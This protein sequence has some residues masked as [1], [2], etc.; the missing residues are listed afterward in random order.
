[1]E[2]GPPGR[3]VSVG[4]SVSVSDGVGVGVGVQVGMPV[5]VGVGPYVQSGVPV[6]TGVLVKGTYGV[7]DGWTVLYVGTCVLMG[8]VGLGVFFPCPWHG[9]AFTSREARQRPRSNEVLAACGNQRRMRVRADRRIG[10]T[11]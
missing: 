4:V 2:V 6:G 3:T 5:T 11:E 1:M 7:R 9:S 10:G 8:F